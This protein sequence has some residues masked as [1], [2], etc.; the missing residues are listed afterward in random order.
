MY[1]QRDNAFIE[2]AGGCAYN[3]AMEGGAT[4]LPKLTKVELYEK[5]KKAQIKGRSTMSKSELVTALREH[6]KKI[7]EAIRLR[8]RA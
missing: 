1:K 8:R 4:P 6:Y 7:G 3:K 5:A 2:M